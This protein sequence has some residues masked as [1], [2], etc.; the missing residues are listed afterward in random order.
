MFELSGELSPNGRQLEEFVSEGNRKHF[1]EVWKSLLK[2]GES[3][4]GYLKHTTRSGNE[5]WTMSSLSKVNGQ[6]EHED[7]IVWL[8]LD[9]TPEVIRNQRSQVIS[10]LAEKWDILFELDINGNFQD[11]NAPFRKAMNFNEV[12]LKSMMIFDVIAPI[13]LEGFNRK[14]ETLLSG[15]PCNGQFRLKP[16]KE[17]ELWIAGS[18][19][20]LHNRSKEVTRIIFSGYNVSREKQLEIENREQSDNL[21]R[22]EKMLHDAE[23]ELAIKLKEVKTEMNLQL[24]A[25]E[26]MKGIYE[27]LNNDSL[28]AVVATGPDNRI[29][30]F[31][32]MAEKIWN[33]KREEVMDQD[34]SMLFPESLIE[35]NEII[36][37]FTRPGDFKITGRIVK[38]A[39]P[40]SSGRETQV[41]LT[42][43]RN[44][45]DNENTFA[46]HLL[47][48]EINQT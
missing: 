33:L 35:E 30:Y 40:A 16:W 14:W 45:I 9:A 44:R 13:D 48:I 31:N 5:L 25:S 20:V 23:K 26:R 43:T 24:K 28:A 47:P 4:S 11:Y 21:K 18:F 32:R 27:A 42:L 38:S 46:A 37:S 17:K 6:E 39:I 1:R 7:R 29:I 12:D 15:T 41:M 22:Q 8:A 34:I 3:F 10:E 36:G 2:K 19:G